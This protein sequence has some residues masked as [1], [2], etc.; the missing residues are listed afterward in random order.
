[1]TGYRKS[2][3]GYG[4]WADMKNT[5]IKLVSGIILLSVMFS[6][7]SCGKKTTGKIRTVDADT[8]WFEYNVFKVEIETDP[9][10]KVDWLS[11][12]LIGCDDRYI[13]VMNNL[14]YMLPLKGDF[15]YDDYAKRFISVIDRSSK[16]VITTIDPEKDLEEYE[17]IRSEFYSDGKITIKT[18]KRE[19]DFD[20]ETGALLDCR[21]VKADIDGDSSFYYVGSYKIE[22]VMHWIDESKDYCD[23]KIY[24]P[25]G[26]VKTVELKEPG[27]G[28]NVQGIIGLSGTKALAAAQLGYYGPVYYEV[29]LDSGKCRKAKESEYKWLDS[30][31]F[32][33]S[34]MAPDG[35]L[36]YNGQNGV[37]RADMKKKTTEEVLR[38]S[39]S[40][41]NTGLVDWP[42]LIECSEDYFLMMSGS[43]FIQSY[44][45]GKNNELTFYEFRR[46]GKNP[47]A[48]KTVLELYSEKG[49]DANI[50]EAISRFNENNSKYFIEIVTRYNMEYD[51]SEDFS[52]QATFDFGA[53]DNMKAEAGLSNKLAVDIMNGEGP[54]ILIGTAGY[55][56]LNNSGCLADL[57]PYVGSLDPDKYFMNI[58]DGSKKDGVLYQL[59]I[60]FAVDGIL[61]DAD[62]AGSSGV[63]FTFGEYEKFLYGKLNGRDAIR[64]GQ[65]IYFSTLFNS[66]SDLFIKDGK[67]DLTCP[68]FKE[69][70]DYVKN[71]VPEK[72]ALL[73]DPDDDDMREVFGEYG[74]CS[75]VGCFFTRW[76]TADNPTYLGLPSVD[77]RGPL[78]DPDL[79]VAISR[80]APDI[81]ACGEF[82]KI[83]L[84][85]EIQENIAKTDRFV[86]NRDAYRKAGK[87]AIEY[88]NNGG[89][90]SSGGFGMYVP[91]GKLSEKDLDFLEDL[92]CSCSGMETEDPDVTII[93]T[94]EMPAYFLGQKD[95]DSV[96]KIAQ[97]RIQKVLDERGG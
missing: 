87:T 55:S 79:S 40:N 7:A 93:L 32:Y 41:V 31:S 53:L 88:Y 10:K 47:N 17:N 90:V 2:S 4:E 73:N 46:A 45:D 35:M 13:V 66:M 20:P 44:S 5:A 63:G 37:L 43:G 3:S 65:A 6:T 21:N 30:V 34:Y 23:L 59:P 57:S 89:Q 14:S 68:E 48:G 84:S 86:I 52:G 76:I 62:N 97:N 71:N 38:F 22:A 26:E 15:D 83:L 95:L 67:A 72:G 50:G 8:P 85:E 28:V 54:D 39:W 60:S 56:R 75:G 12:Q 16:K 11:Q 82:V 81:D 64:Y 25:Q 42:T 91:S 69:L 29:D 33:A 78:F 96:I 18:E 74:F 27:T 94:E 61:T 36:Y 58:I 92:I 1:M 77:G 19:K 51:Y 49:I 70:A 9:G 80:Q 24:S